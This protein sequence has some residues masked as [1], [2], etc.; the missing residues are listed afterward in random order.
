MQC[1]GFCK[2]IDDGSGLAEVERTHKAQGTPLERR[3]LD[4][5]APV[6]SV[7]EPVTAAVGLDQCRFLTSIYTEGWVGC[8]EEIVLDSSTA[9]KRGTR[10]STIMSLGFRK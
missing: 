9:M 7:A 2:P 8:G 3:S 5:Q 6:E 1:S 10:V 4:R